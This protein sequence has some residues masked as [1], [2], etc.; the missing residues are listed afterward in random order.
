MTHVFADTAYWTALFNRQDS[1]HPMANQ[2]S[3]SLT[4]A[5]IV[6]CDLVL[7]EFL[8]SFSNRGSNSRSM[9]AN[10]V[11]ALKESGAII[12][13]LTADAFEAALELYSERP[14]KGWSLTDC[15]SFLVMRQFGIDRALTSDKHFEQAG[16]QALLR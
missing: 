6:T 12:V 7:I 2:L 3:R 15:A 11:K 9:A 5:R 8:N 1:L 16:F 10:A 14:D 4:D 13:P